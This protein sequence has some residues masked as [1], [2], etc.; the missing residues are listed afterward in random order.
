MPVPA[1]VRVLGAAVKMAIAFA[2]VRL[3]EEV[4][5]SDVKRAKKLGKRLVK[6][7]WNGEQFDAAKNIGGDK[8]PSQTD[9]KERIMDVL[10]NEHG[11]TPAQVAAQ[12]A[13]ITEQTAEKEL[14]QMASEGAV[15]RPKTG[16]YREV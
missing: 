5:E 14:E 12:V 7:N 1:T 4:S 16:E 3:Q 11:K 10:E 2:R 6:Q 8:S 15:M 9:R 13:G